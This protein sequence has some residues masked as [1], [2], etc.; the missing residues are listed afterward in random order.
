[1]LMSK[2]WPANFVRGFA[3]ATLLSFA[4]PAL[5]QASICMDDGAVSAC[6]RSITLTTA[7]K[8]RDQYKINGSLQIEVKNNSAF[9]IDVA[10]VLMDEFSVTPE[11]AAPMQDRPATFSI[12]GL[13]LCYNRRDCSEDR[14]KGYTQIPAGKSVRVPLKLEFFVDNGDIPFAQAAKTATFA[15]TLSIIE[16]GKQR[17]AALTLSDVPLNNG[18][19]N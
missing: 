15:G 19:S 5:A 17:F 3:V 8:L 1:M 7:L 16:G 4:P 11:G 9:P 10:F 18:L 12:N 6:T 2:I 13:S 14:T